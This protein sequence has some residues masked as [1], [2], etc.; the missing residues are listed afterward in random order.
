M[1]SKLPG[2]PAAEQVAA[3]S[4]KHR[5]GLVTLLFVDL[6]GSTE[7]KQRAGDAPGLRLIDQH[8]AAVRELVRQ[9]IGAEEISTAGDS[10]FLV[11]ARPSD[12]VRFALRL[13][14]GLRQLSGQSGLAL[15]D[16]VGIHAGE[17]F[18]RENAEAVV[19]KD[20]GGLH[21]DLCARLMSLAHGGQVLMTRFVFDNARQVLKGD[22]LPG[23]EPLSWL[24]HGF[25]QLKGIEEPV[26]VCEV[27]VGRQEVV[28]PPC[29]TEKARRYAVPGEEPVL[30]WRPAVSQVVPGTQW[31][32]EAKLGEGGFGEV[33]LGRHGRLKEPRVFKFCF[34]ADRVRALKREMTLFRVLRE[35]V[36]EHPHIVRLLEVNLEQPPFYLEEEYVA[37]RDL[38]TWFDARGRLGQ[39]PLDMRLE[40]A[41]QAAEGL[42]AAH[43]AGIIHRDV[44]PGNILISGEWQVT[45]DEKKSEPR[46]LTS[47]RSSLVTHHSSL[48]VRLTDFG[49]GQVVSAEYLAGVTATGFTQTLVASTSSSSAGTHL[50]MA[51][52]LLAGRPATVRSDIYSLGVVLYQLLAGDFT[53]PVTTDWARDIQDPL[54]KEDLQRCFA[55][56]PDERFGDAAELAK[57]LRSLP[58]RRAT[59]ALAAKEAFE[60]GAARV[61]SLAVLPFVNMSASPENEFLSDGIAEDLLTA[62]SRV[63]GLRVPGRTS[64]FAF[65]GKTQDLRVIG[66]ALNVQTVLEGSVRKAGTRLRVTAQLINVAD[67]FHL[68]SER[69]DREM[70]DVFAIQ[71]DITQAIVGALKVK[72]A[73]VQPTILVKPYS[74]NVEA[75]ELCLRGRY[76]CQKWTAEGFAMA[77]RFFEQALEREPD[78]PL[79]YV[80]LSEVYRWISFFGAM[81]PGQ[82][83]PKAKAAAL[84]ALELDESLPEA[85]V[86]LAHIFYAYDWDWTG[87]EREFQR[88]LALNP[89]SSEAH[90]WYALFLWTRLRYQEALAEAQRAL[91]LDPF[92]IFAS[93]WQAYALI[94]LERYDEAL[95]VARKMLAMDPNFWG[96]YEASGNA[97]WGK[98]MQAEAIQDFEKLAALERGPNSL[99]SLCLQY[100]LVGRS[101][102]ARQA[103][104]QLEQMAKQRYV[105]P[106]FL[107]WGYMGV[108][109]KDQARACI[110]RAI[111]EHDVSLVA[112]RAS[113]KWG[114]NALLA[115]WL[116]L[117]EQAGL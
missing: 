14:A 101:D 108:G 40:I 1:A 78:H 24:N 48:S 68:W 35:R 103:L 69:Y 21:V 93:W 94:S 105:Q 63:A 80:G 60:R 10:F 29:G 72:L 100:P 97:R 76:H 81:P 65:K 54:L 13:L 26:E 28:T 31:V 95:E 44:K 98:G 70:T 113:A 90:C 82:G 50:Y 73:A 6:V 114:N 3:F 23:V 8:H 42:A 19:A 49:V 46:E 25:Y 38:R 9:F 85:H 57:N 37:G 87:A 91:E 104:E 53:R 47:P 92:S 88:A 17:V 117:L 77:V 61:A 96:A 89:Q 34:R 51:P 30:G 107:A 2:A 59:R 86:E 39:V 71:D 36:G 52:E 18:E 74:G 79:A 112:W 11:F 12:A 55:G 75:Y 32:L 5:T 45:S 15:Q 20:L 111:K 56:Q 106:G 115:D 27:R 58:E 99:G 7:L 41:A 67:G 83:V 4:Q 22:E 109:A 62:L 16:R 102:D 43:A 33:W 66:Q 116:G 110:E 84:R 64:C